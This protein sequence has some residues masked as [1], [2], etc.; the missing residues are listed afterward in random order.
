MCRHEEE[1]TT[2]N[3]GIL[4]FQSRWS[5][6]NAERRSFHDFETYVTFDSL[7]RSGM[8]LE[9]APMSSEVLIP[10]HS[11][12]CYVIMISIRCH[13][14]SHMSC[15]SN[16][17]YAIASEAT[18]ILRG[19]ER[20]SLIFD[21]H[22]RARLRLVLPADEVLRSPTVSTSLNEWRVKLQR[23]VPRSARLWLARRRPRCSA[24]LGP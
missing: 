21:R 1:V 8:D 20:G 9:T 19:V 15:V 24:C 12:Q 16:A 22:V 2:N 14:L 11:F 6:C 3:K 10:E 17:S 23:D 7:G 5:Y 18:L 13:V 4:I